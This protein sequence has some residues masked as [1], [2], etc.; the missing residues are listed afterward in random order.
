MLL[1]RQRSR[2][3]I[4]YSVAQ[5]V[6]R[7]DARIAAPRKGQLFR[8]AHA[9][10]LVVDEVRRHADQLQ[11]L[12]ALADDLVR[13]REWDEMREALHRHAVAIAHVRGD[14][15]MQGKNLGHR[16]GALDA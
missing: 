16:S 11:P 14:R 5:P 15:I 9:D 1:D 4:F 2:P 8:R 10:Q 3:A 13:G 7:A 6:E 12:A